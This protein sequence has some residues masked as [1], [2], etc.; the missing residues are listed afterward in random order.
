VLETFLSLIILRV[1]NAHYRRKLA[2]KVFCFNYY[3]TGAGEG[4]MF[5]WRVK[6][7]QTGNQDRETKNKY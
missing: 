3:F 2:A 5:H 4:I 6:Q 1:L 7:N